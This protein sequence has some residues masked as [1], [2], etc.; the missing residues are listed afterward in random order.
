VRSIGPLSRCTSLV[1]LSVDRTE[2][3]DIGAL[4]GLSGLQELVA[5]GAFPCQLMAQRFPSFR[6]TNSIGCSE[7]S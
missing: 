4:T 3:A 2:V 7:Q 1:T 6:P 5:A